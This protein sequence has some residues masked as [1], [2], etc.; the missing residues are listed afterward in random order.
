M[1]GTLSSWKENLTITI[2]SKKHNYKF[3]FYTSTVV[4]IFEDREAA[5]GFTIKLLILIYSVMIWVKCLL[6]PDDLL[7]DTVYSQP[8]VYH[9]YV[10]F[11]FVQCVHGVV[12]R[13]SNTA[14]KPALSARPQESLW[15][16]ILHRKY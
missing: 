12:Q 1:A 4:N 11:P 8:H 16:T 2:A 13:V 7:P 5:D 3:W 14:R 6:K 10:M 15:L 9:H